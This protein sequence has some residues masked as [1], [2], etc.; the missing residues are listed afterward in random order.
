MISCYF[1]V[2]GCGKTTFLTKFAV[3]QLKINKLP[4]IVARLLKKKQYDHIYS[5]VFIDGA[6]KIAFTDLN[7]N[8]LYNSLILLD[9][10]A[11]EAD[12]RD[13]KTF[14]TGIRDFLIL[15]RHLG[16]DII[17][18]TQSYDAVDKKIKFLTQ[19]LW[20]MT[21]SV[22]PVLGQFSFA[23]RIY[24]NININENTSELVMGYRFANF[25][26]RL[27]VSNTKVCFMRRY[28]KY[29]DSFE[30]GQLEN[31]PVYTSYKWGEVEPES[32]FIA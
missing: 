22:V 20:Y 18:V 23:R 4:K 32:D 1:G 19:D 29:F 14:P 27:F 21:K 10:L 15:H 9:E 6:E 30:E 12:N 17:Y 16:N 3:K 7:K 13:F 24:R 11:M 28:F 2:P 26:E 25:L 5:N 8:K 31:R